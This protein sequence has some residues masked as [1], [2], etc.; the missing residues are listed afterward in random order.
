MSKK[1]ESLKEGQ[2]AQRKKYD[3]RQALMEMGIDHFE[4]VD[5][6]KSVGNNVHRL[7]RDIGIDELS[8]KVYHDGVVELTD[9]EARIFC[10]LLQ[11]DNC[12]MNIAATQAAVRILTNKD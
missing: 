9:E 2:K 12:D 3:F 4:E 7:T 5:I 6:R 11:S 10:I 1:K 8:R